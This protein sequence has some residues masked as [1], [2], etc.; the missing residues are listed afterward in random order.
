M[1]FIKKYKKFKNRRRYIMDKK[2]Q[3]LNIDNII[4]IVENDSSN[5]WDDLCEKCSSLVKEAG[6]TYQEIDEIVEG[7]KV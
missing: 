2:T 7:C 3:E 1:K 4:D 6:M 5:S